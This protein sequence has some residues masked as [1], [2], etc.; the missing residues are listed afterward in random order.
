[1]A[2][3][4]GT[5]MDVSRSE[6]VVGTQLFNLVLSL[7]LTAVAA[8]RAREAKSAARLFELGSVS[9]MAPLAIFDLIYMGYYYGALQLVHLGYVRS[10]FSVLT[11][12][13]V[14]TL[15]MLRFRV[16]SDVCPWYTRRRS[17]FFLGI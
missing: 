11:S 5:E 9:A 14:A 3:I 17:N 15:G 12:S 6:P 1:M 10:F 8:S 13:Q 2:L 16:F 7:S 4:F